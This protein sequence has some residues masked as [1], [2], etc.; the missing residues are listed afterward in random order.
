LRFKKFLQV[1]TVEFP[2]APAGSWMVGVDVRLGSRRR[3]F[4][5]PLAGMPDF[6]SLITEALPLMKSHPQSMPACWLK[7]IH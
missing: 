6:S 5:F 3:F 4:P 1:L 2:G 7:A